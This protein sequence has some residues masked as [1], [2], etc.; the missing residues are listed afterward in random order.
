MSLDHD[1]LNKRRQDREK[2]RKRRQRA[3][4]IKLVLAIIVLIGCGVGIFFLI[5]NNKP[6]SEPTLATVPPETVEE[7]VPPTE[8][9]ASWDKAPVKIHI[10]IGRA[11]V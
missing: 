5:R 11:H 2:R 4:Y 3:M 6:V 9:R 1:E 7:T 8:K 10:E